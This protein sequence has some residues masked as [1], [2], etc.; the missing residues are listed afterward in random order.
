MTFFDLIENVTNLTFCQLSDVHALLLLSVPG[1]P[2][3]Y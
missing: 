3:F 1:C 2:Y